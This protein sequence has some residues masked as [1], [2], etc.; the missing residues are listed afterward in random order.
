MILKAYEITKGE[1]IGEKVLCFISDSHTDRTLSYS[2]LDEL[3]KMRDLIN[4]FIES[5]ESE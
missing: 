3:K 1:P 4:L 5:E 2:S